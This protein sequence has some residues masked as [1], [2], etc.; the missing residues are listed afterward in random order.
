MQT[1]D[2]EDARLCI[3]SASRE[4]FSQKLS[5]IF[6][7]RII[8]GQRKE[9][10]QV[11]QKEI[12]RSRRHFVQPFSLGSRGSPN[13]KMIKLYSTILKKMFEFDNCSHFIQKTAFTSSVTIHY[14][15]VHSKKSV[16]VTMNAFCFER[17]CSSWQKIQA[18]EKYMKELQIEQ[19]KSH[20]ESGFSKRLDQIRST[21]EIH[22][23]T[24]I[25]QIRKLIKYKNIRNVEIHSNSKIMLSKTPC[26][27]AY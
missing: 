18:F 7:L 13:D 8:A 24:K 16:Y 3:K 12:E 15:N 26:F 4:Q 27:K 6:S 25:Y 17:E 20:F 1:P 10:R 19:L 2:N 11:I 14:S 23:N 9:N 22:L 21:F 5:I